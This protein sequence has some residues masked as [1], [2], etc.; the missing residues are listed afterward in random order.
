[1]V[2][3]GT[4]QALGTSFADVNALSLTNQTGVAA[5]GNA[6]AVNYKI[7]ASLPSGVSNSANG[8]STG[9]HSITWEAQNN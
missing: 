4:L 7:Q 1:M 5:W 6:D 2:Y 8:L 9:T 3:S